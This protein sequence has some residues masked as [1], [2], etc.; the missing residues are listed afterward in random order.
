MCHQLQLLCHVS[1]LYHLT[2]I[3]VAVFVRWVIELTRLGAIFLVGIKDKTNKLIEL[4]F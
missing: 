2:H 3:R 4:G 1:V